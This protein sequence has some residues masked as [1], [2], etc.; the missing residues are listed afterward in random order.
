[1]AT[2][3]YQALSKE[4]KRVTGTQ[5]A[6]S[7]QE[8]AE[9]LSKQGVQLLSAKKAGGF[10]LSNAANMQ[11]GNNK[12]KLKD[13]VV[14]TR[15]LATMIN[16]GV[17][18]V[19]SLATLQSQ[20]ENQYF[21]K[22]VGQI[23]RDVEG[24]MAFADALAKHPDIFSPIYI[25]MVR[26]GEAGGILD[27]ILKKLAFQQEKDSAIRHKF[28][29]AMTYPVVLITIAVAVFIG[30]MT[31]V[32]P[33]IGNIVSDL[34][35]GAEL[36]TLTRVMM[37]ISNFMTTYWYIELIFVVVGAFAFRRWKKSPKG[38]EQ[39]DRML[40][41]LPAIGPIVNKVAIARFARTFASLMSAG[42]SVVETIEI[43]SKA[44]G[45]KVVEKELL[46]AA[47]EVA[48][49]KQL[50]EPI[51]RS[52]VFP[53]I[54]SQ[55]LAIGEETGQTDTILIKVAD[56]YEEEVD[57]AVDSISSI[58]EPILIVFMGGMVGLVAASVLGPISNLS[59]QI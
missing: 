59:Q 21:Q 32:V 41:K 53:P 11:I 16:A 54:V 10:S 3:N 24:G 38:Q 44:I 17:P 22:T 57:A 55:M 33:K 13:K 40:F 52:E 1:M 35:N 51:S 7:T 15:Q 28:K 29:S 42:V 27:E 36:P 30:L 49:G 26:A 47:K 45:N 5:D 39:F 8:L 34:T 48:N 46:A 2:F 58:L 50:S 6:G 20:T 9:I 12:P 37:Q 23:T 56:F 43:T 18:L 25:N 31:V 14:F 19:R 4:N